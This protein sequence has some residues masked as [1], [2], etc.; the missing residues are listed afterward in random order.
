MPDIPDRTPMCHH[1]LKDS[2]RLVG[3]PLR[4]LGF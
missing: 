2:A 4:P 1:T 3:D